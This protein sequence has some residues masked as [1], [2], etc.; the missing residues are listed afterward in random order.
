MSQMATINYVEISEMSMNV[1]SV[2]MSTPIH[3]AAVNGEKSTIELLLKSSDD[4]PDDYTCDVNEV[5]KFG[6]TALVYTVFGD[7][8]DCAELLLRHKA[9]VNKEDRDKRTALHWAAYLGKPKFVSLF[10]QQMERGDDCN[11]CDLE[12]RTPLHFAAAQENSK[13]LRLLLKH[14]VPEKIDVADDEKKTALHWSAYYGYLEHVKILIKAGA[15]PLRDIQYN[16]LLHLAVAN[17]QSP[18]AVRIVRHLLKLKPYFSVQKNYRGLTPLHLAVA[19]ENEELVRELSSP[20][21]QKRALDE[22]DQLSR[23]PLHYAVLRNNVNI[24]RILIS[25]RANLYKEDKTGATALHYAAKNNNF[26]LVALF[27]TQTKLEDIPDEEG[28]TALMWAAS[29]DALDVLELMLRYPTRFDAHACDNRRLTPLHFACMAGN[30]R[31]VRLLLSKSCDASRVDYLGQ[32]PLF[33]ACQQGNLDVVKILVGNKRPDGRAANGASVKRRTGHTVA[34]VGRGGTTG[35]FDAS[36]D[37]LESEN[38]GDNTGRCGDNGGFLV[39]PEGENKCGPNGEEHDENGLDGSEHQ[40]RSNGDVQNASLYKDTADCAKAKE[41]VE[42]SMA[43]HED[44]DGRSPLHF[45]AHAGHVLVCRWLLDNKVDPGKKDACGRIALHGAALNGH[46]NC[47]N[48]ILSYHPELVNERDLDGS[49]A[50]HW[51]ASNGHLEAVKMLVLVFRAFAN[52]RVTSSNFTPLDLAIAGDQQDVTQFL[53]DHGGLTIAGVQQ[54]ASDTIKCYLT[55]WL[56]K[57]KRKSLEPLLLKHRMMT[58]EESAKNS[59]NASGASDVVVVDTDRSLGKED[60]LDAAPFGFQEKPSDASAVAVGVPPAKVS[61]VKEKLSYD[62]AV[63]LPASGGSNERGLTENDN[64]LCPSVACFADGAEQSQPVDATGENLPFFD[65]FNENAFFEPC[66]LGHLDIIDSLIAAGN[67]EVNARD[68]NSCT[69]LHLAAFHGHAAVCR[70]LLEKEADFG[71]RD[72]RGETALHH[73]A[74]NGHSTCIQLLL[75]QK[76]DLVDHLDR[77]NRSALHCAASNGHLE[78]VELLLKTYN[79]QPNV[80]TKPKKLTALDC[81]IIGN[82]RNVVD[83]LIEHAAETSDVLERAAQIITRNARAWLIRARPRVVPRVV[84]LSAVQQSAGDTASEQG[85]LENERPRAVDHVVVASERDKILRVR[86]DWERIA[87]VRRKIHAAVIIQNCFRKHVQRKALKL[88]DAWKSKRNT[89]K[90]ESLGGGIVNASKEKPSSSRTHL[91]R[92]NRLPTNTPDRTFAERKKVATCKE[93][94]TFKSCFPPL[95]ESIGAASSPKTLSKSPTNCSEI[96]SPRREERA[97]ISC[98]SPQLTANELVEQ[99]F[100]KDTVRSEHRRKNPDTVGKT[101]ANGSAHRQNSQ[102]TTNNGERNFLR[103]HSLPEDGPV[104]Q[105]AIPNRPR[106]TVGLRSRHPKYP[107]PRSPMSTGHRPLARESLAQNTYPSSAAVSYN[108]ALDTYHPLASRRGCRQPAFPFK[109]STRVRPNSMKR[110][111]N[112]WVHTREFAGAMASS[113]ASHL[114]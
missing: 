95:L 91:G 31:C 102:K 30:E 45:A 41:S 84:S 24:V 58:R 32:T 79:A 64:C 92:M 16:S 105:R 18:D 65:A 87:V 111:K 100:E 60:E 63:M 69:P 94:E 53:I 62:Q 108:F 106:T 44:V 37:T 2:A 55:S 29:E 51:A 52:Y 22:V 104:G 43:N 9:S 67:A 10:L 103:S 4:R 90:G 6:R 101:R 99:W 97:V 42:E 113:E 7:W 38:H 98:R 50:L 47:I 8:F 25:S 34:V 114:R 93:K 83:F 78:A 3:I 15:K 39:H 5:D 73:A 40:C 20:H 11:P 36:T 89:P 74:L 81:A 112:G 28:R 61:N 59:G 110:G 68:E 109:T 35:D 1:E 82:H 33:K 12:G 54:V 86:R 48:A 21:V 85:L 23:S 107:R 76:P 70:R 88:G 14:V 66:R 17:P 57:R 46:T 71:K 26:E 75:Q 96:Q 72:V 13:C 77:E 56:S 80:S 49:C 19:N 27:V